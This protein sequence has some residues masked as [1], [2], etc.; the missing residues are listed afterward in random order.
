MQKPHNK[1]RK[2]RAYSPQFDT[3]D[4]VL[5]ASSSKYG[6][7]PTVDPIRGISSSSQGAGSGPVVQSTACFVK[8][9][10]PEILAHTF[11][12][13]DASGFAAV[14]LVCR[15][16]YTVASDD[17]AWKAAFDRFYGGYQVIPRLSPSWRG[18]YIHRSHLLRYPTVLHQIDK[19]EMAIR[20]RSDDSL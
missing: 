20:S 8:Q 1:H 5:Q 18:E 14:T 15:E 6:K 10:P 7:Q 12:F 11:S 9:V 3:T 13:L 4:P 17:L 16:W 2:Q 19:K